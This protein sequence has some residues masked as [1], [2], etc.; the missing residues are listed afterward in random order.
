MDKLNWWVALRTM[1]AGGYWNKANTIEFY[2][3]MIKIIIIVPGLLFGVS[4]WWLYL[5]SLGT[6]IALVWSSTV[7][8]LPTI[9]ILN[10]AWIF[11]SLTVIS[12]EVLTWM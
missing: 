2:A 5:L 4:W 8:T 6:S 12:R 11:I 9:I 7:K 1:W 10:I 3:F